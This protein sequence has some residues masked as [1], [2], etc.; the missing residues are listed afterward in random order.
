MSAAPA[1]TR[2]KTFAA[3]FSPTGRL[4]EKLSLKLRKVP[5]G[6]FASNMR[7]VDTNVVVRLVVDDDESQ[8]LTAEAFIRD[9]AWIST[10]VL[11]E[12][13]WVLGSIYG[14]RA[15]RIEQAVSMLLENESLVL[16]NAEAVEDALALFRSRPSLGFSDCLILALAR[17]AGHLPLGTFDRQLGKAPGARKL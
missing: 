2:C 5:L 8:V 9:G 17:K 4:R 3:R 11:F 15:S 12:T 10:V 14:A 6:T 7:A 13:V 16:E 1:S